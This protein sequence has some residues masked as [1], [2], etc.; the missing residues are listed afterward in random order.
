[1]QEAPNITDEEILIARKESLLAQCDASLELVIDRVIS[2]VVYYH[3]KGEISLAITDGPKNL[4]NFEKPFDLKKP[5]IQRLLLAVIQV[6]DVDTTTVALHKVG[7]SVTRLS[8]SGGF[9][10]R[11]NVTLLL[12]LAEGQQELALEVFK[13]N[14]HRRVEYVA[15]PLEGAPFP[16][17]ITTAVTVGGATIFSLEVERF[18]EI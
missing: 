12:G 9:L 16:L 1:L 5:S 8:S 2:N 7:L 6:R 4:P 10:G 14:C 18:E 15:T 13:K 3:E 11:Q 17:P